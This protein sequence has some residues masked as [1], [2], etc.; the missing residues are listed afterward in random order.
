MPSCFVFF[1]GQ[2]ERH[3]PLDEKL[4]SDLE[5]R[6][7]NYRF[8]FEDCRHH[9]HLRHLGGNFKNGKNDMNGK[10]DKIGAVGRTGTNEYRLL[11]PKSLCKFL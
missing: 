7:W 5:W 11:E 3:I 9:L 8:F 4:R 1:L 6:I 2:R 10:S